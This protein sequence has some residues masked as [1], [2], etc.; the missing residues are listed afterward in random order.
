MNELS[1]IDSIDL[2]T[3]QEEMKKI[4]TFQ[5]IVQKTLKLDHDYGKIPGVDK[6]S[7]FKPGGEK[8]CMLFGLCPEYEIMDKIEDYKNDFFSYNIKCTLY[9]NDRPFAQGIGSCNSKEKKYR[10]V[11]VNEIPTGYMGSTEEITTKYG[12]TKYRIE[13]PDICSLVN[14][15]LKMSKK[16]SFIDSVLQVASLSEIFTQ[17]IE[18]IKEFVA[19]EQTAATKGMKPEQAGKIKLNFGKYKGKTLKE[20][21]QEDKQY[22]EWLMNSEKTDIE[23]KSAAEIMFDAV[24]EKSKLKDVKMEPTVTDTPEPIDSDDPFMDDDVLAGM[25]GIQRVV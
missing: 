22:L 2:A 19:E 10:Y 20:V 5:A 6:P 1:L 12:Q 11:T 16:R 23:I 13:N 18:D 14:T 8:I 17:D 9:K 7:L 25:A 24:K 3:I 4:S 15:I 21:Y